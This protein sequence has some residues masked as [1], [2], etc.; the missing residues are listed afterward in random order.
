MHFVGVRDFDIPILVLHETTIGLRVD[1]VHPLPEATEKRLSGVRLIIGTHA[2]R[3]YIGRYT[4]VYK[5]KCR[6]VVT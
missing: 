3:T 6:Y 1:G 4:S 5:T 2:R